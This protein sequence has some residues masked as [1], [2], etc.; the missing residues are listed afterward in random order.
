MPGGREEFLFNKSFG[1]D[2]SKSLKHKEC[3]G[4]RSLHETKIRRD[5]SFQKCSRSSRDR[6]IGSSKVGT[7][8]D[9]ETF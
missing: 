9:L 5:N 2:L 7:F 6:L 3:A 1:S 8:E 4:S